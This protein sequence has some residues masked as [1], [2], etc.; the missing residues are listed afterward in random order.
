MIKTRAATYFIITMITSVILSG[1]N[2]Q[3]SQPKNERL[4]RWLDYYGLVLDDFRDTLFIENNAILKSP[5]DTAN[6]HFKMFKDFYIYSANHNFLIDLDSYFLVLEKNTEGEL[7][8]RGTAVDQEVALIDIKNKIRQRIIFCGTA[9]FAEEA[10]WIDNKT[11][12]ILGFSKPEKKSI[13]VVWVFNRENNQLKELQ[14]LQKPI[15]NKAKSYHKNIRLDK[16]IFD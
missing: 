2:Q 7:I 10:Q 4:N 11:I 8:C 5:V 1:C 9:C 15:I 14:A 13:P 12:Y 16:I 3:K 6:I